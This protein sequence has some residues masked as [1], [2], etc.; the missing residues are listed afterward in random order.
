MFHMILKHKFGHR[1]VGIKL[2]W[3]QVLTEL[4]CVF[5]SSTYK[6]LRFE[7]G[8]LACTYSLKHNQLIL[9]VGSLTDFSC[10][11]FL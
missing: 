8:L 5:I 10:C 1:K 4:K 3:P 2:V 9:K 11:M 6:V 7:M